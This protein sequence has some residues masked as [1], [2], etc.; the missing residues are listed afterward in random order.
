MT[1]LSEQ[2]RY[3]TMLILSSVNDMIYVMIMI[4][5][6]ASMLQCSTFHL[7][8]VMIYVYVLNA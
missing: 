6:L 1:R 2:R 5:D 4:R 8:D 3:V 7:L